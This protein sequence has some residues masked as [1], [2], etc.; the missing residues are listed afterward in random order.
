M[1]YI[2][3][4]LNLNLL[5]EMSQNFVPIY[6]RNNSFQTYDPY[7]VHLIRQMNLNLTKSN[8]CNHKTSIS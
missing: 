3:Q 4:T 1:N 8:D 7:F 5:Q 6:L 2:L